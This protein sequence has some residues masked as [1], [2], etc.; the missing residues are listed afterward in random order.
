MI[1]NSSTHKIAQIQKNIEQLLEQLRV[2]CFVEAAV[3]AIEVE[4][5]TN[6]TFGS[7]R[8]APELYIS[9]QKIR[10]ISEAAII[11]EGDFINVLILSSRTLRKNYRYCMRTLGE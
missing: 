11:A 7:T 3:F 1:T 2:S 9:P 5:P 8:I 6:W 10:N 4:T